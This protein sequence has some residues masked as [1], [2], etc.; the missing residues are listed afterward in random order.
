[1]ADCFGIGGEV[2][3]IA[4]LAMEG[5]IP[6]SENLQ[7]RVALLK[8]APYSVVEKTIEGLRFAKGVR[9]L[10]AELRSHGIRCFIVSGGFR[11]AASF[12]AQELGM[13]GIVSNELGIVGNRLS[14]EAAGPAGGEILDAEGKRRAVEAI[15]AFHGASLS[16]AIAVGDGA[17]DL[18]M[19][20]AAGLGA[21]CREKP[22]LAERADGAVRNGS[23]DALPALFEEAWIESL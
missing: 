14:G 16:Q 13:E 18:L 1:M 11:Q 4:R 7:K 15:C 10:A 2:A 21:S 20:G 23:A 3:E 17:N 9:R 22:V 8:D 6:F 12:V 19:A 5:R